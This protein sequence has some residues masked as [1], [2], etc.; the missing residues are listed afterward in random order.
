MN[1]NI[2]IVPVRIVTHVTGGEGVV[3]IGGAQTHLTGPNFAPQMKF[4][5]TWFVSISRQAS[6]FLKII[7]HFK[8][9]AI[10]IDWQIEF[11]SDVWPNKL[12]TLKMSIVLIVYK[13]STF[14]IH[15]G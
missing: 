6:L 1:N 11:Q 3:G 14:N 8:L 9:K 13:V 4:D 10:D 2:I 15:Q 12:Q 5:Y 7:F